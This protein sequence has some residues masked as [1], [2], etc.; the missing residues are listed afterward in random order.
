MK[1]A[2]KNVS[3]NQD[4]NIIDVFRSKSFL[5]L[6]IIAMFFLTPCRS[7]LAEAQEIKSSAIQKKLAELEASSGVRIGISATNTANNQRIQYRDDERFPFASTFKLMVVSAILKQSMVDSHLLQQKVN[8]KK[9]DIVYWSPITKKHLADGMTI[10][11]LC[12]SAIMYSDN[13]ATNLLVKQLG[14]PQAVADFAHSIGNNAFK[15]EGWE[16]NLNTDPNDP[17]DI[18]TPTAME[19]S[20]QDLALGNA[21]A[22]PQREQ[23]VTWLKGNAIGVGRMRAGVPKGWIVAHKTG[24]GSYGI[25]NDIGVI[26][27]PKCAPLVV[28]IYTIQNKKDATP[29]E[30]VVATATRIVINEFSQTDQ[31]I[32][33]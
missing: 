13:T 5:L 14:G 24:S 10:A 33:G 32:K 30:D 8:Y 4:T 26:W 3:R 22:S 15:L 21:L 20:L 12:A 16:P 19:K 2:T 29:R 1:Q 28:A 25:V 11:E 17:R 23:L 27:P 7:S 31:C 9:Q 6:F 18:S